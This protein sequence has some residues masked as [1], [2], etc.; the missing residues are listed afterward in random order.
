MAHIMVKFNKIGAS[1]GIGGM[2]VKK[3]SKS[4]KIVKSP[5]NL[6]GLEKSQRISV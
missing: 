4:Q 6:K 1:G 5:K 2:L 3:L